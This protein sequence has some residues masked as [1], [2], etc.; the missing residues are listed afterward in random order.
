MLVYSLCTIMP[1]PLGL[2]S[3]RAK[4]HAFSNGAN[5]EQ[6]SVLHILYLEAILQGCSLKYVFFKTRQPDTLRKDVNALH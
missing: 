2:N 4:H 5:F 3:T 1:F 6:F